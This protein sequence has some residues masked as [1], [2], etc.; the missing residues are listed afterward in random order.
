MFPIRR[1]S[2][3]LKLVLLIPLA[4]IFFLLLVGNQSSA[5]SSGISNSLVNS[6]ENEIQDR[7]NHKFPL[8]QAKKSETQVSSSHHSDGSSNNDDEGRNSHRLNN[9]SSS[10]SSTKNKSKASAQSQ[11]WSSNNNGDN[12]SDG[13]EME[14]GVLVPPNDTKP[15]EMGKPFKPTNMTETQKKLAGEG[16]KK[17]A[18]NQF[19]SDMI[20]VRRTL[21]DP[22]DEW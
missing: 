17:N 18:F 22:R 10:S 12:K 7:T 3:V 1:R 5:V 11:H 6:E 13:E 15:G 19:V 8:T 21:P 2:F 20:S 4:W 14:L 9:K 16:W